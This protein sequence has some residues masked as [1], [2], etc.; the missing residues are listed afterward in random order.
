MSTPTTASDVLRVVGAR[1]ALAFLRAE[2][3]AS[4]TW[5]L[6]EPQDPWAEPP[7]TRWNAETT[8]LPTL[9]SVASRA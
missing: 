8:Y 7:T 1:A 3:R 5:W 4:D 6:P 9:A 2:V